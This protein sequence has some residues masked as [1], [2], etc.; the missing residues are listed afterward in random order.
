M[1]S[2]ILTVHLLVSLI[3]IHDF[4]KRTIPSPNRDRAVTAK[5]HAA[6]CIWQTVPPEGVHFSR[7][8]HQG[9]LRTQVGQRDWIPME[10][11]QAPGL[12]LR[13]PRAAGHSGLISGI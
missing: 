8:G 3:V 9:C 11:G 12:S 5:E 7:E 4:L 10:R 13:D 6:Q 2:I 1:Q